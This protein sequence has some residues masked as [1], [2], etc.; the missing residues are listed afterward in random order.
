MLRRHLSGFQAALTLGLMR[1]G[2]AVRVVCLRVLQ[3]PDA[4]ASYRGV[5]DGLRGPAAPPDVPRLA[6]AVEIVRPET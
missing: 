5:L 2:A 3:K 4:A 1:I 6:P